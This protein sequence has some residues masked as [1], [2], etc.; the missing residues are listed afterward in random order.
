M[1]RVF[2][3]EDQAADSLMCRRILEIERAA[4]IAAA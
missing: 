3:A 4:D 2:I 1:I